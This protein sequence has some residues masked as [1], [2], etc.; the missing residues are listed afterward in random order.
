MKRLLHILLL[1]FG[2]SLLAETT[3]GSYTCP[4][5]VCGNY[6]NVSVVGENTRD[7]KVKWKIG[8]DVVYE[9]GWFTGNTINGKGWRGATMTWVATYG[10]LYDDKTPNVRLAT[11]SACVKYTC[12]YCKAVYCIHDVEHGYQRHYPAEFSHDNQSGQTIKHQTC[13]RNEWDAT[14]Y[15]DN[16]TQVCNTCQ[17]EYCSICKKHTCPQCPNM[18]ICEPDFCAFCMVEYCAYHNP[19]AHNHPCPHTD[20]CEIEWCEHHQTEYCSTHDNSHHPAEFVCNFTEHVQCFGS[21]TAVEQWQKA[22]NVGPCKK[23][24]TAGSDY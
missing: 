4:E 5:W 22:M 6:Y 15:Q 9:G 10:A 17:G 21:E 24:G 14:H 20:D 13:F 12:S 18:E 23:C 7:L 16:N 2:L 11:D 1:M 19:D 8:D 3:S